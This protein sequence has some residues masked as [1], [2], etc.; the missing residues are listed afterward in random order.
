MSS[1][2]VSRIR[3]TTTKNV[4]ALKKQGVTNSDHL[5]AKGGTDKGRKELASAAGLTTEQVL[6]LVNRADLARIKGIGRQYSNL[7]EDAGVDTVK[8][9]AQRKP[10][11]LQT[12]LAAKAAAS[13]VKRAPTMHEVESWVTQAKAL[14]RAVSY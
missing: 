6:E 12:A 1:L 9:L 2:P 10:D 4:A 11:N 13:G 8:E 14:P 3:G 5:L 7:L